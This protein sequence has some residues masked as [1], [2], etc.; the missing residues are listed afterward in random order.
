[1]VDVE[2]LVVSGAPRTAFV[3]DDQAPGL[4]W[5]LDV[6]AL[7]R[8]GWEID[9]H[10]IVPPPGEDEKQFFSNHPYAMG[11]AWRGGSRWTATFTV[12]DR[13]VNALVTHE[14]LIDGIDNVDPGP[15][16]ASGSPWRWRIDRLSDGA[17]AGRAESPILAAAAVEA[18]L[19][20]NGSTIPD[21]TMTR[22]SRST[23]EPPP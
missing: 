13:T 17:H 16:L 5:R 12:G 9:E 1:M 10:S 20:A 21:R 18:M 6:D 19:I 23:M 11:P 3:L 22:R 14:L 15:P 4:S 8:R 7:R 2:L